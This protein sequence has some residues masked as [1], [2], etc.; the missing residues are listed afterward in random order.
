LKDQGLQGIEI[1]YP[2][3]T[4]PQK[5]LYQE[6][7]SAL[8]LVVTGGTDFHCPLP[9]GAIPGAYGLDKNGY[10]LFLERLYRA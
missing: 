1:F 8:G 9:R 4:K 6:I 7:A 3:H 10:L 2:E 5:K